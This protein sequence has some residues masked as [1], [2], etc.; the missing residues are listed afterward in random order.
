MK[1]DARVT[2][3][4]PAQPIAFAGLMRIFSGEGGTRIIVAESPRLPIQHSF[5]DR[6]SLRAPARSRAHLSASCRLDFGQ[7]PHPLVNCNERQ[8]LCRRL[9][10]T[11]RFG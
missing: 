4:T 7:S 3:T 8:V 10:A 6:V 9:S 1:L 11:H 2:T 5:S